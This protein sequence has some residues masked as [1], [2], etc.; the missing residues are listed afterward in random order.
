MI[1][2][3]TVLV[4]TAAFVTLFLC[5]S[6][7]SWVAVGRYQDAR[8]ASPSLTE[9]ERLNEKIFQ[10]YREGNYEQAI[11]AAERVVTILE[12]DLRADDVRLVRAH[13]NLAG[14]FFGAQK[15]DKALVSY[16]RALALLEASPSPDPKLIATV[17]ERLARTS[18]SNG[19]QDDAEKFL[20]RALST[21]E[22]SS[23][24]DAAEVVATL[25][26]LT[27]YY[28]A[29]GELKK[30]EPP[31]RRAVEISKRLKEG[32]APTQQAIAVARYGCLLRRTGR[33]GE[34]DAFEQENFPAVFKDPRKKD[35]GTPENV[36]DGRAISKP[37][38]VYPLAAKRAGA[39]G[40]VVVH[41]VVDE[42]GNVI[43]ACAISGHPLLR[44]ACEDAAYKARFTPALVDGKPT[45]IQGTITYNFRLG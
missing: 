25:H 39:Q 33:A 9:A 12:K 17:L 44:K 3:R 29:R 19:S 4:L 14:L 16:R 21:R 28:F 23:V 13:A 10:L 41:I 6:P 2:S 7:A 15:Y 22:A 30:A 34:A 24:T 37:P 43:S 26:M 11:P 42:R 32:P 35:G 18:F 1:L 45:M 31:L 40:E 20:L 38:P 36:I 5:P 27:D 8:P